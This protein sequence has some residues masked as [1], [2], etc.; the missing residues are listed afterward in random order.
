MM[1]AT[2]VSLLE[3]LRT[4]Q[5]ADAWDHFVELYS[6]LLF[7]WAKRLGQQDSDAAD[8]VQ[9]VFLLLWRKLPQFR[10]DPSK[11]FHAWLR[12]LFLN[13]ARQRFH[14]RG[15]A[16]TDQAADLPAAYENL[17]EEGEYQRYLLHRALQLIERDFSAAHVAAFREFVLLGR[18]VGD[19]A[20][21]LGLSTG[22]IYCIKSRI[23][24]R[25]R[26]QVAPLLD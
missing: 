6:P 13:R 12:T 15:P 24:S 20:R 10:Y 3:R 25:L 21:E 26:Q 11:R 7:H 17:M 22:A 18:P 9:D 16:P 8:L 2:P 1:Q 5:D 19:V 14:Q 23:L 4:P